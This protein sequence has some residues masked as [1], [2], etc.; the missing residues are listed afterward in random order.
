MKTRFEKNLRIT[1]DLMLYCHHRGGRDISS[2]IVEL[3]DKI[4]YTVTA[5][6]VDMDE[7][8]LEELSV[9]L[10]APRQLEIEHDYWELMGESKDFSELM[11]IGT[12]CDEA[13][14]VYKDGV[15]TITLLRYD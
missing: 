8:K 10:N 4:K 5:F 15:L 9:R 13:D 12:L 11:L 14:I 6:P 2:N 1:G 3:E 7:E